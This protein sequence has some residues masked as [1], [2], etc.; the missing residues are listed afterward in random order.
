MG[1]ITRTCV[2]LYAFFSV[3]FYIGF[4]ELGWSFVELGLSFFLLLLCLSKALLV[5]LDTLFND[6]SLIVAFHAS[7]EVV[8][9]ELSKHIIGRQLRS[10]QISLHCFINSFG[11]TI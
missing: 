4:F 10:S 7:E 8:Q 1:R 2:L 11:F 3:S 9:Y 6:C 5:F